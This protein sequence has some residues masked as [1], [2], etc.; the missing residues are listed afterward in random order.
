[1]QLLQ[2][3]CLELLKEI[4]D[5]SVEMVMERWEALHSETKTD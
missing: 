1:M 2:G 4:P 3:D 5:G